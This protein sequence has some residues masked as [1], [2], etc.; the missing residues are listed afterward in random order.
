MCLRS[1]TRPA[2]MPRIAFILTVL[3]GCAALADR[4]GPPVVAPLVHDG[5]RYE[6]PNR[7]GRVAY[8]EAWDEATGK[9]IWRTAVFKNWINPFLEEDVQWVYIKSLQI[10]EGRVL[11]TDER[12]RQHYVD[13]KTGRRP[14]S[15]LTWAALILVLSLAFWIAHRRLRRKRDNDRSATPL[16]S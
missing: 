13:A 2:T 10:A 4:S 14:A 6:A 16:V 1:C 12:G 15:A 9:Q 3:S 11:V 7:N 8:L 5:V